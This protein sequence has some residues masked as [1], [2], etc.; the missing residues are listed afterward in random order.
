[1][2]VTFASTLVMPLQY[3]VL[4]GGVIAILMFVLQQSNTLRI[5][6]WDARKA[7]WPVELPA[8]T[9]LESNKIT[10]L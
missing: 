5:V 6:E 3:A 7:G 4:M 2:G 10:V 9:K 8:P 1:M